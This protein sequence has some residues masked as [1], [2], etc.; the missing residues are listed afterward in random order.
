MPVS[1]IWGLPETRDLAPFR[2]T[3]LLLVQTSYRLIPGFDDP[4]SQSLPTTTPHFTPPPLCPVPSS[5]SLSAQDLTSSLQVF[6]PPR[7][8]TER[9]VVG[10]CTGA[11]CCTHAGI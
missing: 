11:M 9:S 1:S 3:G 6:L 8:S 5:L 7:P 10:W 2:Y 4:L